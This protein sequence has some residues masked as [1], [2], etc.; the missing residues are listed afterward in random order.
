M[1]FAPWGCCRAHSGCVEAA[2]LGCKQC[3]WQCWEGQVGTWPWHAKKRSLGHMA[4]VKPQKLSFG[5][6]LVHEWFWGFKVRGTCLPSPASHQKPSWLF[7]AL[8]SLCRVANNC[9]LS[10]FKR[11]SLCGYPVSEPEN[12]SPW[13]V[14]NLAETPTSLHALLN[15][16]LVRKV[17]ELNQAAVKPH[18]P[19]YS[20]SE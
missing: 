18:S 15:F 2:W 12:R 20:F 3:L 19:Y 7:A 17:S 1:L 13:A 8:G 4:G 6:P 11:W 9:I 10:S 16:N 14:P 5:F